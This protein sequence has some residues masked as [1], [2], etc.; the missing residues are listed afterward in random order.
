MSSY[1]IDTH[2]HLDLTDDID[3]MIMEAD[4]N[5]VKKFIISGC[6]KKSIRNGLEIIYRYPSIYMTCGFHPDEVDELTDKDMEDLENIIKTNEKIIG[7]GEIGL[8]YFHNDMNIEKQKEFFI[9]QIEL[10]EKYDLPIVVHSRD[11]IQDVYDILKEHHARGVIHCY[12]GS[13]EMAREFIKLGFYLGIGGVLTFKNSKLKEIFEKV[14]LDNIIFETDSPY[15]APEPYRGK[16]NEPKNVKIVASF[17]AKELGK[18][19]QEVTD[20][21]YENV[22]KIYNIE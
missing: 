15:L 4:N 11:S 1:L 7:V 2:C 20:A 22:K 9:K 8:D 21:S 10:A 12:S 5:N 19:I 14:T 16:K 13:V 6:D 18:T 17:L 3:T